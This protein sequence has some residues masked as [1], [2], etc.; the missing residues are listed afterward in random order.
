MADAHIPAPQA[1]FPSSRSLVLTG[2]RLGLIAAVIAAA[3]LLCSVALLPF[4]VP[5]DAL[6]RD[7]ARHLGDVPPLT[8]EIPS[9]PQTSVIYAADHKT[10]LANLV[11]NERRTVVPLKQVPKQVR[12]AVVAIEDDRFYEHKGVDFRGILRAAIAD[13]RHGGI[14]QGGITLTQQYVQKVVTGDSRTLERKIREAMYAVQLERRW[15]KDQILGAYLNE[16]YFGDGLYGI[17]TAAQHY[18]GGKPVGKLS[19]AEGAALAAT[20]AAPNDYNP[21]RKANAARRA[22]VLDRMQTLGFASARQVATA[23][24]AKLKVNIYTPRTRQ[25]YFVEY[26]KQQ[27][28]H[29][30]AYDKTLGK[31]DT[32]RRTRTV[33]QGG[34]RIYTTLSPRLQREG[35]AAIHNQLW[36]RFG[37]NGNPTGALASVDPRD[38]KLLA[39]ASGRNFNQSQVD[40]ATGRGGTGFQPGSSFKVFFLVAAL[41]EGIPTSTSFNSPAHLTVADPRCNVGF[42][43]PWTLGNAGESEAGTYNMYQ[44]TAH[45]VNT[46]FA[47]LAL[48]V[49]VDRAIETARKMGISNIPPR[50]SDAYHAWQVC[51]LVLGVREVSVLDMASAYGVL[52]NKGVRCPVYS[53]ARIED[54]DRK[55]LYSHKSTCSE[56]IKPKIVATMDAMLRGVVTGG[57][58]VAAHLP[59]RPVAGKT[60][61]AQEYRSAFFN[62]Y[63]PQLATSVWVGFTPKPV[64]MPHQSPRGGP[65]F[66]GTY[67]ALIFHD[68]MAAAMA[69]APVIGFPAAPPPPAPAKA[70]VPKVVGKP[71]KQ[72]QQI[73]QGAGFG[74][75]A[76]EVP[77]SAPK[78]RVVAQ[79]PAGGAEVPGGTSVLLK[80]SNGKG[81]AAGDVVIPGVVGLQV[82]VARSILGTFGLLATI[83]YTTVGSNSQV[84]QVISQ[85]PPAGTRVP[86]GSRV[87]LLGGRTQLLP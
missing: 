23:K 42:H 34:L 19:L 35:E 4:V 85:S 8:E 40:L 75:T 59:G 29:D 76:Q 15:S 30:L 67:P 63:T 82:N 20:I 39:L 7:T 45:S 36:S 6:L 37:K 87:T 65:V 16:A 5:A 24:H 46:Y 61:T 57:T 81:G 14:A 73:L 80:V 1:P 60:G 74:S 25:P 48:K 72:A 79:D 58:G 51:S 52:A 56:V 77:S 54:P 71:V 64:S 21:R 11:L 83:A 41:E 49:G 18:F 50:D 70:K 17:A 43:K 38:G 78:G 66:G 69:G 47:Q 55:P 3:A 9:S 22:I 84:G 31:A 68:Y 13:L 12:D 53:I 62:G 33:F 10:V 26:I 28:L 2:S 86:R 32:D 44:A 27:L